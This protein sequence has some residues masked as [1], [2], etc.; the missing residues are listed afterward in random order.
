MHRTGERWRSK[1]EGGEVANT[2]EI[3][4]LNPVVLVGSHLQLSHNVCR[5]SNLK[6]FH[7]GGI[8]IIDLSIWSVQPFDQG[9]VATYILDGIHQTDQPKKSMIHLSSD[10]FILFKTE[11]RQESSSLSFCIAV[12]TV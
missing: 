6:D 7:N 12:N 11:S 4:R 10:G 3:Y 8:C 9:S 2:Y 1:A 5:F